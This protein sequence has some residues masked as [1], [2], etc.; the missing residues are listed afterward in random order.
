MTLLR[1]VPREVYRVYD[2]DDFFAGAVGECVGSTSVGAAE[3][4][5][6]RIAGA[7]LLLGV[8]GA[9]GG[10]VIVNSLPRVRGSGRRP[11]GG[12]PA[13]SGSQAHGYPAG[14]RVGEALVI[15]ARPLRQR[16]RGARPAETVRRLLRPSP[17]AEIALAPH[18]GVSTNSSPR[19]SVKLVASARSIPETVGH[20]EFG[21]ER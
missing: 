12:L 1:R 21:F 18:V 4:R 5:V 6:S 7:A 13:T 10:L 14:A 8:V 15:A 19:A 3:G 9:V 11:G 2:E 20:I 16:R 17:P